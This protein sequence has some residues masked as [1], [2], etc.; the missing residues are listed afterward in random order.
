MLSLLLPMFVLGEEFNGFGP[1]RFDGSLSIETPRGDLHGYAAKHDKQR[2]N[3]GFGDLSLVDFNM[4]A[5]DNFS[6][7]TMV[8]TV[9]EVLD[10]AHA[11][12]MTV[13]YAKK[14]ELD[15]LTTKL[16]GH[17]G[18]LNKTEGSIDSLTGISS[19]LPIFY[20]TKILKTKNSGFFRDP[21]HPKI[22]YASWAMFEHKAT[23]R[24]F[25][26]VN[27]DLYRAFSESTDIQMMNIL[28]SI[29]KDAVVDGN[30]IFFMGN[31]NAVDDKLQKLFDDE[32]VNPL[33]EDLNAKDSP[34]FT[35]RIPVD[36]SNNHQRDFL[37]IRDKKTQAI[38]VNYARVLRKDITTSHYPVHAILSF[39]PATAPPKSSVAPAPA[40]GVQNTATPARA[41]GIPNA[42][43]AQVQSAPPAP[44]IRARG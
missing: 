20:D 23:Q 40:A 12:V 18:V 10:S 43:R 1:T 37:L 15:A 28:A 42:P 19:Y 34:R 35:M 30:P 8:D 27:L 36:I 33:D 31:I 38:K 39:D 3:K 2:S 17:Y 41:P 25:T 32:Y 22:I 11:S 7:E 4:E 21:K 44:K 9:W 6:P 13:Q 16:L 24:I 14:R 29:K 5:D 26:V